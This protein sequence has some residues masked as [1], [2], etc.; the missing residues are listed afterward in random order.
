MIYPRFPVKGDLIGITAPSAGVGHKLESYER[1]LAVLKREGYRIKETDSVR[2]DGLRSADSAARAREFNGLFRDDDVRMILS[3]T[4]G[5]FLY[6]ILPLIDDSLF[7]SHPKWV[8]GASDPTSILFTMTV[9]HDI[10]TLYG[11][12]AGG[13]DMEPFHHSLRDCLDL[14]KGDHVIQTSNDFI[15]SDPPFSDG[16]LHFDQENHWL[17]NVRELDVCGRC[18]GG[19]T[20]VLQNMFGTPYAPVN[21]FIDRYADD[22]VIWYLDNFALSA[23][24]FYLTLLQMRYA[25]YFRTAKAVIIGR[26]IL[27]SSNTGMTYHEAAER[28]LGDIPFFTDADIG[29]TPGSMT[30]INGALMRLAYFS[31]KAQ[32]SFELS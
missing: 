17:S 23:E 4:G 22:G 30:M 20:D 21:D 16:P 5:D 12:N 26:M 19:C 9:R 8:M 29:H 27:P 6:E 18:I 24:V 1:S 28:A 10:A 25:G 32:V 3:A 11:H 15:A 31:G 2:T 13:F 7:R 14:M